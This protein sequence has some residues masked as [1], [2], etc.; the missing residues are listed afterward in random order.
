MLELNLTCF[1]SCFLSEPPD[2]RI[3]FSSYEYQSPQLSDTHEL[4]F[5]SFE[6]DELIV[7]ES[8]TEEEYS[9][10]IFRKTKSKQEETIALGR[11]N[12]NDHKE[13]IAAYMVSYVLDHYFTF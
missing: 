10:G 9:C 2:V 6:K 12:S 8:D 13:N 5:S 7:E 3:W 11:L 4:G 1:V